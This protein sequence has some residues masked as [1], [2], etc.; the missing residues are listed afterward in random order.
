[1]TLIARFIFTQTSVDMRKRKLLYVRREVLMMTKRGRRVNPHRIPI[2]TGKFNKQAIIRAANRQD[3]YFGWL[4]VL[5]SM[6][7]QGIKTPDEVKQMLDSLGED[8]I[9]VKLMAWE[10]RKAE[11]LMGIKEPYPNLEFYDP[12]SEGDVIAFA[13]KAAENAI[14]IALCSISLC[15][16]TAEL[17]NRDELRKTFSNVAITLA[18][19]EGGCNSYERIS[20]DMELHHLSITHTDKNIELQIASP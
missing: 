13:R 5:H 6:L 15:L 10:M 16:D 3:L 12:K 4:L 14:H 19:I 18:E 9:R 2:S 17:L 8:Q 20:A 11:E 1:M 7:D